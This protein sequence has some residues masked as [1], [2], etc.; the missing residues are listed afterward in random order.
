MCIVSAGQSVPNEN[1]GNNPGS[2]RSDSLADGDGDSLTVSVI[3]RRLRV[4]DRYGVPRVREPRR[5]GQR[6]E[7]RWCGW[8]ADSPAAGGDSRGATTAAV[9]TLVAGG[10]GSVAALAAW[11]L[12][13]VD[14]L[15]Q[16]VLPVFP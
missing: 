1:R 10:A 13:Q 11:L 15:I 2:H 3:G 6:C 5:V 16:S 8:C 4:D 9:A 14:A 12:P 7:L